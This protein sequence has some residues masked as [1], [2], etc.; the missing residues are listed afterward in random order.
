MIFS[1]L[2][3]CKQLKS[4]EMKTLKFVLLA[5]FTLM[6]LSACKSQFLQEL[7]DQQAGM[8]A[9]IHLL[10]DGHKLFKS[11]TLNYEYCAMWDAK[12]GNTATGKKEIKSFMSDVFRGKRV[13]WEGSV[14]SNSREK[15]YTIRILQ[16]EIIENDCAFRN[17]IIAGKSGKV[18]ATVKK[19]AS[20]EC[21]SR[22]AIWFEL[23]NQSGD[24]RVFRLD[25]WVLVRR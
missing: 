19:N 23:E 3:V 24:T 18:I 10:V 25:P 12:Q 9:K 5:S 11:P 16:I 7:E 8:N 17:V 2:L 4:I 14:D 1:T 20:E 6:G 22:Y 15:G 13:S 21:K